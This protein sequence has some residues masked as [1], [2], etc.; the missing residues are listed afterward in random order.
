MEIKQNFVE[1]Q[2]QSFHCQEEPIIQKGKKSNKAGW[3][4]RFWFEAFF[5]I[6]DWKKESNPP[7]LKT[8]VGMVV[9]IATQESNRSEKI[10]WK[11]M[12]SLIHVLPI[13]IVPFQH[14]D[15]NK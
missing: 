7:R 9:F 2:K 1:R 4:C 15:K 14:V 5:A 13:E 10:R 8:T 12:A 3:L 6:L 11:Q